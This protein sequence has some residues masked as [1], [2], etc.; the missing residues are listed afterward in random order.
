MYPLDVLQRL[1]LSSLHFVLGRKG[2]GETSY[3]GDIR[4]GIEIPGGEVGDGLL[5]A[6]LPVLLD[7]GPHGGAPVTEHRRET[8]QPV[9]DGVG[10]GEALVLRDVV[11]GQILP[12]SP[13]VW[14]GAG[15]E[16]CLVLPE[17]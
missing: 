4:P 8:V 16:S 6:V 10:G 17:I 13:V 5:V 12:A 3:P 9:R 14:L 2:A 1:R 11:G 7:L 15:S